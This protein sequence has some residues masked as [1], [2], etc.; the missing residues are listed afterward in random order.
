M[1]MTWNCGFWSN[2]ADEEEEEAPFVLTSE[3]KLV[4]NGLS[5]RVRRTSLGSHGAMHQ[6]HL[7]GHYTFLL[8]L[9]D[10]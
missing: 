7:A 4:Q 1:G 6:V 2:A 9:S 5:Q 3:K 10:D 8:A